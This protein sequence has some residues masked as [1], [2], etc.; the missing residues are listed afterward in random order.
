MTEASTLASRLQEA[1]KAKGYSQV[2]L[3]KLSGCSQVAISNL[4]TGESEV[5]ALVPRIASVLGVRALWLAEGDGEKYEREGFVPH[6]A[7]RMLRMAETLAALP[8]KK[9]KA[10]ADLL[11]VEF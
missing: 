10:L 5:S 8:N 7:P 9:L 4:E 11:D 2:Q 1:R 3:A 6:I